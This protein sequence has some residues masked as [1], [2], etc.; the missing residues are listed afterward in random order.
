MRIICCFLVRNSPPV[1][2]KIHIPKEFSNFFR[3]FGIILY[4]GMNTVVLRK[5]RKAFNL[6]NRFFKKYGKFRIFNNFMA[7]IYLIIYIAQAVFTIL[8]FT[9]QQLSFMA[10]IKFRGHGVSNIQKA[11]F[12]ALQMLVFFGQFNSAAY[13]LSCLISI[14]QVE[15]RYK[16]RGNSENQLKSSSE[17]FPYKK[18]SIDPKKLLEGISDTGSSLSKFKKSKENSPERKKRK[19]PFPTIQRSHKRPAHH[20]RG[21]NSKKGASHARIGSRSSNKKESLLHNLQSPVHSERDFLMSKK[22][23]E[24]PLPG[25]YEDNLHGSNMEAS[26]YNQS[27]VNDQSN[28]K[29]ST[30]DISRANLDMSVMFKST[31]D[32]K[33]LNREKRLKERNLQI[34]NK[35]S[36]FDLGTIKEAVFA[37]AGVLTT[38]DTRIGAFTTTK[39]IY[40]VEIEKLAELKKRVDE[41]PGQFK[42][43]EEEEQSFE[44][45]EEYSE[46]SQE[47]GGELNGEF[48]SKVFDE[49]T[50][51]LDDVLSA[52]DK[53]EILQIKKG[54]EV[55]VRSPRHANRRNFGLG[56]D[57]N[58]KNSES[59]TMG[60]KTTSVELEMQQASFLMQI[61]N[62]EKK[63]KERVMSLRSGKFQMGRRM[64][65][66]TRNMKSSRAFSVNTFNFDENSHGN[67]EE[68]VL[69]ET[70]TSKFEESLRLMADLS[71]NKQE[72]DEFMKGV[73]LCHEKSSEVKKLIFRNFLIL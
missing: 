1:G 5:L 44:E 11:I 71:E 73:L 35:N 16:E 21:I 54:E 56:K 64:T 42:F 51:N 13:N 62:M 37:K 10:V 6:K 67:G 29:R 2:N 50:L 33:R 40:S 32:S 57:M 65:L 69:I 66:G 63:F 34:F 18:T 19:I 38:G 15:D 43:E 17:R 70:K 68:E 72:I 24:K 9:P 8:S 59:T 49:D 47:Y 30:L 60:K 20:L 48:V 53:N 26:R 31:K 3:V 25:N 14:L 28:P 41:N 27:P 4:T 22:S 55:P 7:L 12:V 36:L 39:K 52:I 45:R 46:K 23:I 61:Q 58:S